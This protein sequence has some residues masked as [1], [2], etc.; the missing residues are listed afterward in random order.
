MKK[1]T[2]VQQEVEVVED[3]ICNKCEKSCR[4]SKEVPD[5]YGLIEASFSTGYFSEALPDGMRY[6]FS[7][8][9]ECLAELFK[10]FKIS[11]EEESYC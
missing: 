11:P 1:T 6:S 3:V 4:P 10:S 8:C 2:I 5:F 9:E 7:L